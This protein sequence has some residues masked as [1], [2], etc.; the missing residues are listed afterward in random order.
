MDSIF[1][2]WH[3]HQVGEDPEDTDDKLIG[4]YRSAQDSE[5][6]IVRLK[7]KPGFRDTRNGFQTCEYVIGRDHWTEG[8][9][10]ESEGS[11]E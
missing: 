11:G 4:V 8:Y 5:A 6:A 10:S 3:S 1:I 7:D 2:L 9:I